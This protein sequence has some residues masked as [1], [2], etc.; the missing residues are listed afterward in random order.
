[1]SGLDDFKTALKLSNI[2]NA[3][4]FD[5]IT[6]KIITQ[7]RVHDIETVFQ[8]HIEIN[9]K[10]IKAGHCDNCKKNKE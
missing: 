4:M 3:S 1:M 9:F 10:N 8:K 5:C 7:E 2:M 6:H